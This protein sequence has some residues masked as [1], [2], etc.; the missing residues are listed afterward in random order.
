[1]SVINLEPNRTRRKPPELKSGPAAEQ[2]VFSHVVEAVQSGTIKPGDRLVERE[3]AEKARA[4]RQVIRNALLRL[5]DAGLV[6]LSPNKGAR[7]IRLSA[8]EA[9]QAFETRIVIEATLLKKL[10][11]SFDDEAATA[12]QDI[13]RA[14]SAAYDEGRLQE[15]RHHSRA[16][17]MEIGRRGGNKYMSRFL[18]DLINCQPLLQDSRNGVRMEFSG[19]AWHIKTL[20]ALA[21]GDGDEAAYYNTQLLTAVQ[22]EMLR[23]IEALT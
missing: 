20:A 23:D 13:L 11:T 5:A 10:A 21:R 8:E 18:D 12:L 22:Q 3:L 6:E 19:L 9:V 1:M 4:N 2:R 17:H 14:E 16:F 15:G 7:V